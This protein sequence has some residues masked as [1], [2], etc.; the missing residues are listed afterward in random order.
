MISSQGGYHELHNE[1]DGVKEKVAEECIVFIESH[2]DDV[3]AA[4]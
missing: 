3:G 2:L 1:P 4:N